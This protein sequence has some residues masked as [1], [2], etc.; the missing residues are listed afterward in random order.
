MADEKSRDINQQRDQDNEKPRGA[1]AK[2]GAQG[3]QRPDQQG[4]RREQDT[5]SPGQGG[6]IQGTGQR[7]PSQGQSDQGGK[8]QQGSLRDQGSRQGGQGGQTDDDD[9]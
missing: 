4:Q 8:N 7:Q 6:G 9:F 3:Q 5:E 2:A 1:A